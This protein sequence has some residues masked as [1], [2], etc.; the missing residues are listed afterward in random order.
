[1]TTMPSTGAVIELLDSSN[2]TLGCSRI[3]TPVLD[4][5]GEDGRSVPVSLDDLVS[6]DKSD[7]R[8]VPKLRCSG[9]F[10]HEVLSGESTGRAIMAHLLSLLF[11]YLN[12]TTH[13]TTEV[14][15][16]VAVA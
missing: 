4:I 1:M 15:V 12:Y 14:A 13:R 11:H 10:V 16:R 2:G 5:W 9:G 6:I 7:L 8:S 3:T